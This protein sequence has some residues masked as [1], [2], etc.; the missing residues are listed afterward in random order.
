M[1][2]LYTKLAVCVCFWVVITLVVLNFLGTIAAALAGATG[3]MI[4]M[5]AIKNVLI[6]RET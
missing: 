1:K 3:T 4:I 6:I 2:Q 5:T